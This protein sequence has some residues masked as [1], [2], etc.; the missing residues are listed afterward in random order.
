MYAQQWLYQQLPLVRDMTGRA[1]KFK[2]IWSTEVGWSTAG[3][4]DPATQA[5]YIRDAIK[6]ATG[7]WTSF[8]ART[9]VYTLEKPHNG[10]R[11][12][13]YNL[14]ND[15]LSPKP[16]WNALAQALSAA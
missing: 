15:D 3:D 4:V 13:G 2:P 14:L 16:A 6:R 5:V 12:G 7:E 9:F 10:D 11:D 8:V 1:G